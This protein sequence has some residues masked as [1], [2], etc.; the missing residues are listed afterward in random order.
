MYWLHRLWCV[1]TPNAT[2][3]AFSA[4]GCT[5]PLNRPIIASAGF[6]GINRGRKKLIVSATHS[7]MA[8][9]ASLR[10]RNLTGAASSRR[11]R[12]GSLQVEV[13]KHLLDVRHRES[14]CSGVRILLCRPSRQV[15]VVV[16]VPVD[17]LRRRHYRH[18]FQHRLL[19]LLDEGDLGRLVGSRELVEHLVHGRVAVAL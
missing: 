12:G 18:V 16:L 11:R 14:R 4:V 8:K 7:V 13:E 17:R 15:L 1:S 19:D 6:P 2:S 5:W 3:S 9:K 10:S